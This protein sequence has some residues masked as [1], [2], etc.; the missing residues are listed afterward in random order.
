MIPYSRQSISRSDIS[1]VKKVL[2]SE[3]LTQG[4][5]VPIFENAVANYCK[6]SHAVAVNSATSALHI[7]CLALNVGPGDYVWTS[8]NSFVASANCA[9]YCGANIDFVDIDPKTYN[10]STE[11]LLEKLKRAKKNNSLPKVV[12]PV[13][14]AG[15]SCDMEE[16]HKL[17]IEYGFKIIE[18]ASH[19]L[20]GYYQGELIGNCKF[21]DLTVFS[22]HPVKII[23]TGE[24][25]MLVT[26][27]K[28]IF[29]KLLMFRAHG[30]TRNKK[31]FD[32]RPSD[33]I[34]NYQQLSIGFNFRMTD[35]Q[36][37]LGSS[38]LKKINKLLTRRNQIAKRYDKELKDFGIILPFQSGNVR[39]SFHLYPI[40]VP[41]DR[42]NKLYQFMLNKGI[43]VNI[44]Y[45]PIHLQPY[46][47][48]FGFK[49]GNF[50][51]A[52]KFFNEE[53]S[54]PIFPGLKLKEQKYII[55]TLKEFFNE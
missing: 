21:S 17:S 4:P 24:G 55:K 7:A 6:T 10:M 11:R 34:W 53:I 52:E 37:A 20:S 46:Y 3:Y 30:I 47:K 1:S 44:H 26:N 27:N 50:P 41:I 13:H 36:A 12:I 18:D 43:G 49:K 48:D 8:P 25:G 51:E 39:S 38:Q 15:Q 2:K 40:R 42:R 33:E 14:F 32:E 54:L 23:T 28:Q 31:Q 19:A 45:I 5:A 9:M 29:E 35:L 16:I 22:F